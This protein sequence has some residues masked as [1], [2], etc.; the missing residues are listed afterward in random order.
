MKNNKSQ[1]QLILFS[2]PDKPGVE[3]AIE[4]FLSFAGDKARIERVNID[5]L[6]KVS[7]DFREPADKTVSDSER[8]AQKICQKEVLENFDYAIVFGGDGSIISTV[9]SVSKASL[10]VVGVNVGKLGFLAEYSVEELEGFFTNL[11]KGSVPT[12]KRMMIN[13]RIFEKD[14]KGRHEKFCSSAVNDICI[15]AG[16]PFRTIEL[17]ILVDGQPLAG[18]VSDGLIISTPTGSTAYNLS[19][20]GPILSPKLN[21]MVITPICPHSLSFRPIVINADNKVEVFGIRVNEGTTV[22]ID[23][24][25]CHRLSIDDIVRVQ[26]ETIDFLIVNNPLRTQWDTLATKLSWAEKP[27]YKE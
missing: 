11:I 13:C 20:G 3:P 14:G 10:P 25:V 22:T 24:Q 2:D 19:A 18:C 6:K 8:K 17:K 7:D 1:L 23:G 12:E 21:A 4:K 9:R 5:D 27:K 16:P 15:T 26:R